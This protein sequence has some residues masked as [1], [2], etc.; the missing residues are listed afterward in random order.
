MGFVLYNLLF[1]IFFCALS[2]KTV[3]CGSIL[4]IVEDT[5]ATLS[6]NKLY[7]LSVA[8]AQQGGNNRSMRDAMRPSEA[9]HR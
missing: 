7:H 8:V 6:A 5:R 2:C 1:T 4:A 9:S 3:L